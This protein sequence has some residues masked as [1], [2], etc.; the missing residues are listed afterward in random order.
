MP[1]FSNIQPHNIPVYHRIVKSLKT[2]KTVQISYEINIS[3]LHHI[4]IYC[5]TRAKSIFKTKAYL[6]KC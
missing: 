2:F 3:Y 6:L 5:N 4:N 1:L